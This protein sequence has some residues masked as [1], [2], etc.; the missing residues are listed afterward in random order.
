MA[1]GMLE[2]HKNNML[3]LVDGFISSVAFLIAFKIDP[4]IKHNAIFSHCSAEKGHRLL[5]EY[6]Q[7]KEVL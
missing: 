4:T 3:L 1:G 6:L 5:L 2:A 7:V